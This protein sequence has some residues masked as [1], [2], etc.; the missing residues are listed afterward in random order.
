MEFHLKQPVSANNES[1]HI[2]D[3]LTFIGSCFSDHMANIAR[4]RGLNVLSNPFG[5]IFHPSPIARSIG[6]SI[7]KTSNPVLFEY[8][9]LVYDWDSSHLF[10]S[11]SK[12]AH[13][14]KINS[15]QALIKKHLKDDSWLFI[16]LGTSIAYSHNSIGLIVA[17]CHKQ[18]SKIF[19]KEIISYDQMV[20]EWKVFLELLYAFN[21]NLKVVFTV[22]PVRHLRDGLISNNIS[23]AHLFILIE[24]L[25]SHYPVTY[26]P[27]YEIINDALRD[28]RFFEE[29]LT[30]PNKMAIEHVWEHF[31]QTYFSEK[32]QS[33]MRRISKLHKTMK[34]R[35]MSQDKIESQKLMVWIKKERESIQKIIGREL[36]STN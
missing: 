16:T 26:F 6:N 12:T 3:K 27:S 5:T 7:K 10:F 32:D 19:S 14:E 18:D 29:D 8:N 31:E 21:K 22:S 1:I 17:N 9:N 13:K 2:D 11:E 20:E 23:K 25:M 30:H 35:V 36:M 28:Y 4:A 34:H 15:T 24:K 33:L